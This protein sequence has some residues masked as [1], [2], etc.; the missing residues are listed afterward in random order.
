[1]ALVFNQWVSISAATVRERAIHEPQAGAIS[2]QAEFS[3]GSPDRRRDDVG[4]KPEGPFAP[5][6]HEKVECPPRS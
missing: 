3:E 2:D 4:G 1:V 5:T 6:S